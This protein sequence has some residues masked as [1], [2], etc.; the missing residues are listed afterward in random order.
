MDG[1]G[2]QERCRVDR[3]YRQLLYQST[4]R[5]SGPGL[6]GGTELQLNA[7]LARVQGR[8]VYERVA[9]IGIAGLDG[10]K[11]DYRD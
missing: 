3:W 10:T 6:A 8:G 7:R 9:P 4:G 1:G 2:G 11:V 5:R